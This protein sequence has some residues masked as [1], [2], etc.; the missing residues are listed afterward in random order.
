MSKRR[1]YHRE[2]YRTNATELAERKQEERD[3]FDQA[4][5]Y[6]R[7]KMLFNREM[8]GLIAK[9][10]P[11]IIERARKAYEKVLDQYEPESEEVA[12]KSNVST[13]RK[14]KK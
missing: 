12:K 4:T 7:Q 6:W 3:N 5:S 13:G 10:P 1:E 8:P 14:R 9:I 2:Y 11:A